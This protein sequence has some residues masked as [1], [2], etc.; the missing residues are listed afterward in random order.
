DPWRAAPG[1]R[2]AQLS[3][4]TFNVNGFNAKRDAALAAIRAGGADVV[5]LQEAIGDW[6]AT[7]E[8]LRPDYPHVGPADV[9]RSRGMVVLSRY[10]ILGIEQHQPISEFYPYLL[11]NLQLP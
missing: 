1:G 4:M 8:A 3:L 7:L 10:P 5:V 11:A 2:G 9:E 6:P